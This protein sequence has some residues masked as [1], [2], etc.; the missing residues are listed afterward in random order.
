MHAPLTTRLRRI[1][2]WI[3]FTAGIAGVVQ[4]CAADE[5][6]AA[7]SPAADSDSKTLWDSLTAIGTVLGAFVAIY[8]AALSRKASRESEF[9][10]KQAG[11]L[12]KKQGLA[13]LWSAFESLL[14]LS[15]EQTHQLGDKAVGDIIHTNMLKMEKIAFFW[16]ANLVDRSVLEIELGNGFA[17]LYEQIDGLGQIPALGRT[18]REL[19][20]ENPY[21]PKLYQA[22][23]RRFPA[24]APAKHS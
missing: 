4:V 19:I 14:Y 3:I 16:E 8:A 18:G 6:P 21:T 12:L 1:G 20:S 17:L 7:T 24:A 9:A 22:L 11:A 15:E 13:D 23:R 5:K 2:L 10:A